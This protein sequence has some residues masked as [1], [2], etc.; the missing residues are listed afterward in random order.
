MTIR[1]LRGKGVAI[2]VAAGQ[3]QRTRERALFSAGVA[4]ESAASFLERYAAGIAALPAPREPAASYLHSLGLKE[5]DLWT[6]LLPSGKRPAEG[7]G[8]FE[9][10]PE[11]GHNTPRG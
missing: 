6:T 7:D 2:R 8:S 11:R 4:S 1:P 9:K 10:G 5:R 3:K